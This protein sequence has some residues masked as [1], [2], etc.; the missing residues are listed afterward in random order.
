MTAPSKEVLALL[1]LLD[2]IYKGPSGV[3]PENVDWRKV[4]EVAS[5]NRTLY[6]AITRLLRMGLTARGDLELS[7]EMSVLAEIGRLSLRVLKATL[8]AL[9]SILDKE[10]FLLVKT[11]KAYPYVT[12]DVDILV[13]NLKEV[14]V[15]LQRSGFSLQRAERHKVDAKKDHLL[16]VSIHERISWGFLTVLDD[17]VMWNGSREGDIG[18]SKV[19][20]P[21]VEGDLLSH[22]AHVA[23]ELYHITLGDLLYMCRLSKEANLEVVVQQAQTHSWAE[24]LER[25]ISVVNG[26]HRYLFGSESPIE[27][28]APII[29]NMELRL[30]FVYPPHYVVQA[31]AEKGMLRPLAWEL[32]FYLYRRVRMHLVQEITFLDSF[33]Y[34]RCA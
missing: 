34:G 15:A 5:R 33:L 21:S 30:P 9:N 16:R 1:F 12:A 22:F 31:F 20:L 13:R 18:G 32:P 11:Y 25:V 17:E 3:L 28:A 4:L 26:L 2:D 29:T 6:C 19:M 8:D 24:S 10:D 14:S 7:K 23:F 27:P